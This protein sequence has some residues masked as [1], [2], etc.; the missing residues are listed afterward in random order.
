ML[1]TLVAL[2]GTRLPEQG[3]VQRFQSSLLRVCRLPALQ[4]RVDLWSADSYLGQ[5]PLI[6]C[7]WQAESRRGLSSSG[8]ISKP[9]RRRNPRHFNLYGF[10]QRCLVLLV[11]TYPLAILCQRGE[12]ADV[13]GLG[14]FLSPMV[15]GPTRAG[16]S[17]PSWRS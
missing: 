2:K 15:H 5:L 3:L 7:G 14:F 6:R 13:R 10:V 16:F 9:H 11:A 1:R 8:S 4:K 12:R 17:W